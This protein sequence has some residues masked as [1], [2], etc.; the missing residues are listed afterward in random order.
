MIIEFSKTDN[1][2]NKFI[3]NSCLSIFSFLE[4]NNEKLNKILNSSDKERE[5][6]FLSLSDAKNYKKFD[7]SSYYSIIST[8]I[9]KFLEIKQDLY[10]K[11]NNYLC[12]QNNTFFFTF[13]ILYF[14][15]RKRFDTM[16]PIVVKI[17]NNKFVCDLE[18]SKEL[19]KKEYQEACETVNKYI[20]NKKY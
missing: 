19:L 10:M 15:N 6:C 9:E 1:N 4:K 5:D 3:Y 18:K 14:Y 20:K 7:L 16:L 12:K 17:I 13:K 2:H 8:C 11:I